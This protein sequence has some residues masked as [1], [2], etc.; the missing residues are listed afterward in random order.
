MR[1]SS[2]QEYRDL[3]CPRCNWLED[4]L[5]SI[6]SWIWKAIIL[7]SIWWFGNKS[8]FTHQVKTLRI[9]HDACVI[10]SQPT[11]PAPLLTALSVSDMCS[12]L[13]HVLFCLLC[14]IFPSSSPPVQL[15]LFLQVFVKMSFLL[16]NIPWHLSL[17]LA[18]FP[19]SKRVW[20]TG[21]ILPQHPII[22][23]LLHLS[24]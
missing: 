21:L 23:P 9:K 19:P 16:E 11:S 6:H 15:L 8:H 20:K 14:C 4:S 10:W 22:P 12:G 3:Y 5:N 18:F 7:S 1:A 17:L 24:Q 2:A 13:L